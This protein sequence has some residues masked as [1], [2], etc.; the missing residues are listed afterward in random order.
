MMADCELNC[1]HCQLASRDNPSPKWAI[2]DYCS[3]KRLAIVLTLQEMPLRYYLV[4][5]TIVDYHC[6]TIVKVLSE[7]FMLV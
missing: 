2:G 7:T 5:I 1:P 6:N 4:I 3:Q